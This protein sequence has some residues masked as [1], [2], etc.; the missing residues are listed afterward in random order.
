MK[1]NQEIENIF[2][3]PLFQNKKKIDF[4]PHHGMLN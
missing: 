1:E 3:K 2:S 4:F